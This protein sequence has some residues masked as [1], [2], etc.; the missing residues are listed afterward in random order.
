MHSFKKLLNSNSNAIGTFCGLGSIDTVE[1]ACHAGFD[2]VVVDG[3]HG[4]FDLTGL[5]HALRAVDAAGGLPIVRL[6]ANGLD[7]VEPLLDAG[8]P[9]LLAPMVN[10]PETASAIVNTAYYPPYG[11]RS[12]SSCRASLRQGADYPQTF[13]REFA[14]I[15]ML[16]HCKAI[17]YATEILA[18]PGVTAGF[19]GTTDLTASLEA[20]PDNQD[21][22][23]LLVQILKAA[24]IAGKPVGIAAKNA[25]QARKFISQGFNFIILGTD[26]R[27]LMSAYEKNIEAWQS[28][29][30]S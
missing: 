20:E 15:V 19:V 29:N 27:L 10:N 11:C 4:S 7:L 28:Y 13:N 8:Y 21:I 18:V 9:A 14:L 3:Q 12:R 30:K 22:E 26:R 23:S 1:L 24:E 16:E 25:E 6:P 17:K 5:V 2:F